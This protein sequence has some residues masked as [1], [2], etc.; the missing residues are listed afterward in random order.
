MVVLT[1]YIHIV[2]CTYMYLYFG[3]RSLATRVGVGV[4]PSLVFGDNNILMP[5]R[6]VIG[7]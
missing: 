7:L 1:I 5:L 2:T 3:S 6:Y 4:L